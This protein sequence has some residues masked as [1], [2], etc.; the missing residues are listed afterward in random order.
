MRCRTQIALMHVMMLRLNAVACTNGRLA[1]TSSNGAVSSTPLTAAAAFIIHRPKTTSTSTGSAIQRTRRQTYASKKSLP[2]LL[3][4]KPKSGSVVD[5]YQ[6]VS[7][8]CSKCR[9]RLFRY[10]KKNGTKSNLVKCYIERISEDSA[11]VLQQHI[12]M[13]MG[14]GEGDDGGDGAKVEEWCCPKCRQRFARRAT[15]H[16][17][18]ALKMVGGKVRMTKK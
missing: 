7:V 10:K 18:P 4:A 14:R 12:N 1:G 16:G 5:S 17:R 6:T 3:H 8:N 9:T 13:E 15:I 11:G 2:L